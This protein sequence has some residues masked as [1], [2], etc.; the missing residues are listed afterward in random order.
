MSHLVILVFFQDTLG[1]FITIKN[2][3]N[4]SKSSTISMNDIVVKSNQTSHWTFSGINVEIFHCELLT[5]HINFLSPHKLYKEVVNTRMTIH[6]SSFG[7]L[8]LNTRTEALISEVYINA[9]H[10]LAPPT[11]ITVIRST[12]FIQNCTFNNFLNENSP[13]ILYGHSNS[14]VTIHNSFFSNHHTMKGVI[15][16]HNACTFKMSSSVVQQNHAY[17]SHFSVFTFQLQIQVTIQDTTFLK[18]SALTGGALSAEHQCHVTCDFCTLSKNKA[19]TGGAIGISSDT[20]LKL[21]NCLFDTNSAFENKTFFD[22]IIPGSERVMSFNIEHLYNKALG[23]S[24]HAFQARV[25]LNNTRFEYN[26]AKRGGAVSLMGGTV[27]IHGSLF[28]YN[29]VIKDGGAIGAINGTQK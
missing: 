6:N 14:T 12:V 28:L 21:M 19:V 15:Y 16:L 25:H 5:V 11:L 13:T 1:L 26:Q 22:T 24:I 18:N 23:G 17:S 2:I 9:E 4:T 8:H 10:I 27:D 3:E 7:M 29:Q 20:N